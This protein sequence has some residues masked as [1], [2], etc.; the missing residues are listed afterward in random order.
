MTFK[1][2]FKN[3][4]N[5]HVFYESDDPKKVINFYHKVPR[6]KHHVLAIVDNITG[7]LIRTKVPRGV[8][9]VGA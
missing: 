5:G 1:Y 6:R 4:T 7:E 9:D 2:T 3:I 8:Q